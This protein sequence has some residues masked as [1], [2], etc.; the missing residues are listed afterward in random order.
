L[1]TINESVLTKLLQSPV[2]E[3][4]VVYHDR[5]ND[6]KGDIILMNAHQS[7]LKIFIKNAV[8]L[9]E[10]EW[11]L[12]MLGLFTGLANAHEHGLVHGDLKP[13]NGIRPY[14]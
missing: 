2:P 8:N 7:T 11:M 12:I 13:S 1:I 5:W 3:A 6:E 9:T 10:D 14:L 4:A